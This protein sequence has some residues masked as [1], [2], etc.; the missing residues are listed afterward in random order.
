MS[1]DTVSAFETQAGQSPDEFIEQIKALPINDVAEWFTNHPGLGELLDKQAKTNP[2]II[3][4]SDKEDEFI[5]CDTLYGHTIKPDDYLKEFESFIKENENK[6]VALKTIIH[7]PGKITRQQI[8]E[9][10]MALSDQQYTEKN[11]RKAW[12]MQT[13]QDV[14]ARIVGYIRKAAVGNALVSWDQRVDNAIGVILTQQAWKPA[15]KNLLKSIGE[16]LKTRLALDEQS[17]NESHLTRKYGRFDRIN[18]IFDGQLPQVLESI[19]DTVWQNE[20]S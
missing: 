18:K 19:N 7:Q 2:P 11:L 17:I 10:L 5:E 15:Q 16:L 8:K 1:D 13:N 4:I 3:F 20:A 12:A 9:L 14:A 6:M